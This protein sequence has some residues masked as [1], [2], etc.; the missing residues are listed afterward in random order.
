MGFYLVGGLWFV[1]CCLALV[2]LFT[3]GYV[4]CWVFGVM[5]GLGSLVGLMVWG[6]GLGFGC[7]WF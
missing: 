6:A 2:V 3:C 7:W 5:C 1:V 4:A